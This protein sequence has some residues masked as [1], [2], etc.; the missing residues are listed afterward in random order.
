MRPG[1]S[2]VLGGLAPVPAPVLRGPLAGFALG[3]GPLRR[4]TGGLT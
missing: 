2:R 1:P 3:R 4:P